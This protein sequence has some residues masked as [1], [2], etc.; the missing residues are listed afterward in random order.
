MNIFKGYACYLL[1]CILPKVQEHVSAG[2]RR[3]N[4]R[5]QKSSEHKNHF[6]RLLTLFQIA[7][8]LAPLGQNAFQKCAKTTVQ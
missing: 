1:L 3:V 4:F 6:Y 8:I 2:L 5:K 7:M